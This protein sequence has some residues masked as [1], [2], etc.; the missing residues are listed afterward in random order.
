MSASCSVLGKAEGPSKY[1][2][3]SGIVIAGILGLAMCAVLPARATAEPYGAGQSGIS[4]VSAQDETGVKNYIYV[5]DS[6]ELRLCVY[7][8]RSGK[9]YFLWA[10]NLVYDMQIPY[11]F[12]AN[13]K[14]YGSKEIAKSLKSLEKQKKD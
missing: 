7:T 8:I 1:S 3:I 14:H 9:L 2:F 10:R 5:L 6:K 12:D 11:D 13:G 4:V